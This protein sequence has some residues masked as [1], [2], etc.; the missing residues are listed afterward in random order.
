MKVILLKD[1]K[2]LGKAEEIKEVNDGYARNYLIK[3]GLAKEATAEGINSIKIKKEAEAFKAAERKKAAMENRDKL[4]GKKVELS[5]KCGE[6]GKVFGSITAQ[7][8]ADEVS[9]TG[10]RVQTL[11]LM[12]LQEQSR[13]QSPKMGT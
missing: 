12:M 6:K 2:A 1:V 5:V 7:S 13:Q 11:I 9:K 8:I 4:K 10:V 3:N